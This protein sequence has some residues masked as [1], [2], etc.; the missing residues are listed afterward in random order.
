MSNTNSIYKNFFH[1][2][3]N[4]Q[5]NTLRFGTKLV[6]SSLVSPEEGSSLLPKRSMLF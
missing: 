1:C 4:T 6:P 2:H 5:N 3:K